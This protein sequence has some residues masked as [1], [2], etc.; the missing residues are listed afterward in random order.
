MHIY[1]QTKLKFGAIKLLNTK[2]SMN[3]AYNTKDP[4]IDARIQTRVAHA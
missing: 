4:R 2:K 3:C 1:I